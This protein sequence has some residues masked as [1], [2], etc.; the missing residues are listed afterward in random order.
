MFDQYT[1]YQ[2][3]KTI[4]TIHQD[5][6]ICQRDYPLDW[7]PEDFMPYAESYSA[8]PDRKLTTILQWMT[9]YMQKAQDHFGPQLLLLAHYY[10]GGDIVK[11][12][13]QFGGQVGDSYQLALMA[14]NHPEKTVIIESAVHFMA[15]REVRY[16]KD[17]EECNY[18]RGTHSGSA[19]EE[20]SCSD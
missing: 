19:K 6:E 8:L 2:P 16:C 4:M 15:E 7:Y 9:P 12:V 11:L 17:R 1:T 20:T 13:E 3:Q 5:M 14:E 10:M 18:Q